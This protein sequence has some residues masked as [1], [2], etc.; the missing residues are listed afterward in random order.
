M[1]ARNNDAGA[2]SSWNANVFQGFLVQLGFAAAPHHFCRLRCC[3]DYRQITVSSYECR[4]SFRLLIHTTNSRLYCEFSIKLT[5]PVSKR[6]GEELISNIQTNAKSF[7]PGQEIFI[8]ILFSRFYKI[9]SQFSI[10][11]IDA[12]FDPHSQLHSGPNFAAQRMRGRSAKQ[13]TKAHHSLHLVPRSFVSLMLFNIN[14][15]I[16]SF[17]PS[18]LKSRRYEKETAWVTW[19]DSADTMQLEFAFLATNGDGH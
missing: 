13:E 9:F 17:P 8:L 18:P 12:P 2:S 14:S 10:A 15:C 3:F 4:I 11:H 6:C 7:A 1:Y 16:F 19:T 5:V